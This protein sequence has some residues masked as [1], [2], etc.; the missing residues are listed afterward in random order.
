MSDS[1]TL[2]TIASSVHGIYQPR[3]LESL[4]FPSGPLVFLTF[5]VVSNVTEAIVDS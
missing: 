5:D 2:W 4:P 3:I 1:V